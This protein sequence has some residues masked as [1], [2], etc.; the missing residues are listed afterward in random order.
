MTPKLLIPI[1]R[2]FYCRSITTI[3]P[4]DH[5]TWRSLNE[6][7]PVHPSVVWLAWLQLASS[8]GEHLWASFLS[9]GLPLETNFILPPLP[10]CIICYCPVLLTQIPKEIQMCSLGMKLKPK[11]VLLDW[12]IGILLSLALHGKTAAVNSWLTT[13]TTSQILL[14][15]VD[16]HL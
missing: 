3:K 7:F 16:Q 12:N 2:I 11:V 10:L 5:Y 13:A 8:A 4:L 9:F 15:L 14:I 1:N 6:L